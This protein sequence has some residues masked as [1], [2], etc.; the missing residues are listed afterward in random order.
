MTV[1][2][3]ASALSDLLLN[4]P[5]GRAVGRRLEGERI[6]APDIIDAE[7]SSVLRRARL[8]GALTDDGV[9][10]I[11]EVLLDWPAVRVPS[12][13][14]VRRACRWWANVSGYDALYLAVAEA[15]EASVVTCD[16]RLARAP[17][18]GVAVENVRVT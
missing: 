16:G 10:R 5:S 1:V 8:A 18:T 6:L 7:V 13:L 17:G 3:D 4:T 9:S 14:F 15:A 12:R 11:H 2:L